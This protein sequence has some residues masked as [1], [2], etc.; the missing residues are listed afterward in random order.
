MLI[1]PNK[2]AV[3]ILRSN[4]RSSFIIRFGLLFED[5]RGPSKVILPQIENVRAKNGRDRI[6]TSNGGEDAIVPMLQNLFGSS[7][8]IT[9]S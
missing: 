4:L 7:E 1:G 2:R 3:W 5:F 6:L 8:F 9:Q